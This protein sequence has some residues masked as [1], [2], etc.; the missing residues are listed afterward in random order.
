LQAW[1]VK[2]PFFGLRSMPMSA[3]KRL[4]TVT[5]VISQTVIVPKF[6]A[7]TGI[8]GATSTV[9]HD[10]YISYAMHVDTGG[11]YSSLDRLSTANVK[12]PADGTAYRP[13]DY[14]STDDFTAAMV[15][16]APTASF[17]VLVVP[18]FVPQCAAAAPL[19]PVGLLCDNAAPIPFCTQIQ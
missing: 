3:P 7:A 16:P 14:R 17:N 18:G 1:L 19:C 13:G 9:I 11:T 15:T 4:L 5:E 8:P 12:P 2:P 10:N 6:P